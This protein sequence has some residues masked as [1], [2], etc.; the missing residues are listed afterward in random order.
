MRFYVIENFSEAL[1]PKAR[2][3]AKLAQKFTRTARHQYKHGLGLGDLLRR[4]A[5]MHVGAARMA[6]GKRFKGAKKITRKMLMR[7]RKE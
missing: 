4:G 7:K 6:Q 5:Q 2:E 1:K 3:H